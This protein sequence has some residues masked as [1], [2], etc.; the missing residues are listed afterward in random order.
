MTLKGT[1]HS[2]SGNDYT[3]KE[4]GYFLCAGDPVRRRI[5]L[6]Y[7]YFHTHVT[8]CT[9]FQEYT[10]V[11]SKEL[12]LFCGGSIANHCLYSAFQAVTIFEF[13]GVFV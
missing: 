1:G 3:K 7:R 4:L 9:H 6:S 12:V 5:W 2:R 13:Q 8:E 11:Y 10:F